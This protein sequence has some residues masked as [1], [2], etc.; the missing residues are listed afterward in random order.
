MD[1][2]FFKRENILETAAPY[3]AMRLQNAY[4]GSSGELT[5]A[6]KT[7]DKYPELTDIGY[8]AAVGTGTADVSV[9]FELLLVDN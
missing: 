1:I 7:V 9:E 3:T 6:H 5:Y 4:I 8:M 2:Y